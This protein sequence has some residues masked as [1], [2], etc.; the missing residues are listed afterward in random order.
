[1]DVRTQVR[2]SAT[3]RSSLTAAGAGRRLKPEPSLVAPWAPPGKALRGKALPGLYLQARGSGRD[4]WLI[5]SWL[6]ASTHPHDHEAFMA[7]EDLS[8][9]ELVWGSACPVHARWAITGHL[10]CSFDLSASAQTPWWD[11]QGD[12]ATAG[13]WLAGLLMPR[14]CP[15][16]FRVTPAHLQLWVRLAP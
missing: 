11:H 16:A 4:P 5:L 15:G 8:S 13:A 7:A 6:P 3:G 14:R 2:I 12:P 10:T 1:M 9:G